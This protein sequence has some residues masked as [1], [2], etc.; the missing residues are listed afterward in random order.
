MDDVKLCPEC[1]AEYFAHIEEC[2]GC[3]IPLVHP[4]ELDTARA[5]RIEESA[6]GLVPIIEGPV[7]RLKEIAYGLKS[8]DIDCQILKMSAPEGSSC[9]TKKEGFGVF[10]AQEAAS[11]A[12]GVIASLTNEYK[13]LLVDV[14]ECYSK[15]E[16]P[17]C[18][19]DVMNSPHECPDCGLN[20]TGGDPPQKA[21]DDCGTC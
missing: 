3:E 14:N 11:A 17:A 16:C 6:G 21:V 18:G 4:D 13:E 8:R 5:T 2:R 9:S 20:L 19:A 12:A 7:D 10:V 1:G 15:G